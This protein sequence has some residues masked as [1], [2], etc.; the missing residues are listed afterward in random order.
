MPA[1]QAGIMFKGTLIERPESELE[2][3]YPNHDFRYRRGRERNPATRSEGDAG[4]LRFLKTLQKNMVNLDK[5]YPVGV[6]IK[7]AL[8]RN[9]SRKPFPVFRRLRRLWRKGYITCYKIKGS[10]SKHGTYYK[11]E[12]WPEWFV[13]GALVRE[14]K[15]LILK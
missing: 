14:H 15:E 5:I 1:G 3:L 2:I 8:K 13:N 4:D 11:L 10:R 9:M 6:L 7:M 12:P